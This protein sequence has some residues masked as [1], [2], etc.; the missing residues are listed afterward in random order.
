VPIA[1]RTPAACG[2]IRLYGS[3]NVPFEFEEMGVVSV[4]CY[5]VSENEM[6]SRF[7]SEASKLGADAVLNFSIEQQSGLHVLF[8]FGLH[9]IS[10]VITLRGTAVRIKKP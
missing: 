7:A 6:L 2:N 10:D 4:I 3:Y 1:T 8:G 5:D 9:H